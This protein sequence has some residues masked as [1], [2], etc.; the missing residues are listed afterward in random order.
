MF[1]RFVTRGSRTSSKLTKA[2]YSKSQSVQHKVKEVEIPVPWGKVAGAY[3]F[4][5][6][7][8]TCKLTNTSFYFRQVMG[9]AR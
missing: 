2:L 6:T 9:I 4:S 8:V 7:N 1:T 5:I 3:L